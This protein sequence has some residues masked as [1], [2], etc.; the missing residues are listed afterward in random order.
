MNSRVDKIADLIFK[1]ANGKLIVTIVM[2]NQ[3][4]ILGMDFRLMR[5]MMGS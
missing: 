4:K 2:C 5:G 3:M 1:Q